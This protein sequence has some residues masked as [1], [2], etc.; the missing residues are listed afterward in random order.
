MAEP[1]PNP[2]CEGA[3]RTGP[4]S[5]R[6]F[7][8]S[9]KRGIAARIPAGHGV[10]AGLFRRATRRCC[11]DC[12]RSR[13]AGHRGA[14]RFPHAL[15]CRRSGERSRTRRHSPRTLPTPPRRHDLARSTRRRRMAKR[16]VIVI[17]PESGRPILFRNRSS[18]GHR[19]LQPAI[20]LRPPRTSRRPQ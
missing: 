16:S 12:C 18:G 11:P 1:Q 8:V 5:A 3:L 9:S 20:G 15:L 14:R 10:C 19:R 6:L 4:V 7:M 2:G 17:C 13:S